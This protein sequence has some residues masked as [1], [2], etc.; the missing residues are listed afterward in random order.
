MTARVFLLDKSGSM[1]A[2]LDDTIGGF[3]SFVREQIPLGGTLTLYTF[4]DFC[5]CEYRDVPIDEV[6]FLSRETYVPNGNTALYDAMGQILKDYMG[7]EGSFVILTD[8]QENSSRKYTKSHVKDLVELSKLDV[9]YVGVELDSA[10]DMGIKHTIEYDSSRTPELFRLVSE[11]VS[12]N[13]VRHSRSQPGERACS[14]GAID[15]SS[16]RSTS[17]NTPNSLPF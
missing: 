10:H 7:K 17:P 5:T 1:D 11:S 14:T 6:K 15:S 8:G 12:S 13:V 4:S 3:N 16:P 2:V 9:M